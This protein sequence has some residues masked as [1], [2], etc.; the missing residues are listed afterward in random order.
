MHQAERLPVPQ[1]A[2]SAVESSAP[3]AEVRLVDDARKRSRLRL[4]GRDRLATL[5]S[6]L[7][8]VA[9]AFALALALPAGQLPSLGVLG[10]LVVSYAILSRVEFELGS[11]TV[12]PTELALVPI[13]LLLPPP[14]VAPVVAVSFI[15][16]GL[17]DILRGRLHP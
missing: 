15:L 7:G 8:F 17:P 1:S 6:G 9:T 11:G 5:G 12:L 4:S 10:L 2:P 16:G 14:A 3:T 13:L